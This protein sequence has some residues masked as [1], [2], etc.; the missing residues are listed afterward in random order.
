[1]AESLFHSAPQLQDV[2]AQMHA[3]AT[4]LFP[5]CRSITGEGTR[6]TLRRL[7]ADLPGMMLHE[8]PTGTPCFDWEIP[9]EWNI[10]DAYVSDAKGHRVIDF[11]KNNLHVVGYSIPVDAEVDRDELDKHL[12]SLPDRPA[13]I[14]YITSYYAPRWGFC[15]THEDRLKLGAGPFRVCVDS[16]LSHGSLTY[17]ELI[18]PGEEER[19]VLLSTYVCHPSMANNELSG[20]VVTW[21]LA[22]WLQRQ[23]HRRFTY[24]IIFVPETIGSIAYLSRNANV[25]RRNT[26]AGYVITCV[27]DER[28]YSFLPS[29]RADT[30]ADRIARHI[31]RHNVPHVDEYTFLD[32]GSDERQYCSPGIDLPVASIMRS[33]YA[34]YPEYHTSLDDLTLVTPAGLQG[35][36][37]ILRMC[38]CAIEANVVYRTVLPCEPQMGRRGLYPTLGTASKANSVRDMMN[39]LAYCDGTSD[40]LAIADRIDLPMELCADI[41]ATLRQQQLL[42][43]C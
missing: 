23:P 24:R 38:L 33:K 42:E 7:A 10:R 16:E 12:F 15:V 39:V 17:G 34:T 28:T 22:R 5:I 14:P 11:R 41:V 40:L 29:R 4:E 21:A 8:I 3:L 36:F 30:L 27:G 32:R 13:A 31:L 25:M 20:P 43:R 18:L 9:P 26:V 19:E 2:G 6:Q 1:M 37:E 35:S